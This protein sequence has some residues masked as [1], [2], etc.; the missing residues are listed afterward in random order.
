MRQV[1]HMAASLS[2]RG[3]RQV[4]GARSWT[5]RACGRR[6]A[7]ALDALDSA[8]ASDGRRADN[9]SIE[10]LHGV[11]ALLHLA[12]IKRPVQCVFSP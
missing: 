11:H 9:A 4:I 10:R 1:W 8:H 12:A 6:T 7:D 3:A 2:R 5:A